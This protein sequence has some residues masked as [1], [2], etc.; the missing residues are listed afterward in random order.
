MTTPFQAFVVNQTPDGSTMGIQQL[1]QRDLPPGEVLIQVAYAAM[2]YKDALVCIPNGNVA[3]TYPLVP[4]L[5]LTG[6]VIESTDPRFQP[7]DPVLAPASKHCLIARPA[8]S[9]RQRL[10]RRR[11]CR[12]CRPHGQPSTAEAHTR[13]H[14]RVRPLPS[15]GLS[16]KS[17]PSGVSCRRREPCPRTQ[18]PDPGRGHARRVPGRAA[19]PPAGPAPWPPLPDASTAA[20]W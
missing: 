10:V 16:R 18:P 15:S 5:E 8:T 7:G 2:N 17:P 6:A 12:A 11:W 14:R 20:N 3:R 1:E 4:G 19:T 9:A 13:R